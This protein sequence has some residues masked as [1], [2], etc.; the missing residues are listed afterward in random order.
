MKLNAEEEKLGNQAREELYTLTLS[1]LYGPLQIFS[2][3]RSQ[4]FFVCRFILQRLTNLY[5]PLLLLP[6]FSNN[7]HRSVRP[8]TSL[9]SC[10]LYLALGH[11]LKN[12]GKNAK[13]SFRPFSCNNK[14]ILGFMLFE[15]SDQQ[16]TE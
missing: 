5:F 13:R 12:N 1:E 8:R 14:M 7:V 3:P 6:V 16:A 15:G 10:S 2:E 9:R 11:L 4:A